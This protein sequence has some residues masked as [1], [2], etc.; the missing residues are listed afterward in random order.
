MHNLLRETQGFAAGLRTSDV[1][2]VRKIN[3][4]MSFRQDENQE[5]EEIF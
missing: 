5:Q 3:G 1:F 2:S 4:G